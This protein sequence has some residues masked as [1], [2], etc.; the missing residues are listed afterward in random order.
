V[1]IGRE[2]FGALAPASHARK[3]S[4]ATSQPRRG[5]I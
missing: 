2:V 1:K 3:N 4:R 5:V